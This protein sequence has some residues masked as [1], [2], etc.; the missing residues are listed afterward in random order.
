[1]FF[2]IGALPPQDRYKIMTATIVPRPIAWI[3][4]LSR[5]GVL[6]A[7]PFSFFN[8]MGNDPPTVAIGIM[9]RAGLL[10]DTAANI[11]ETGEF[12][13]NLVAETDAS[14]MN[15]TCIDAPPEVDELALAELE[16]APSRFVAPPRIETARVAFECQAL[17]SLVTGPLQTI[18]IGRVLCA[19]VED[20]FVLDAER[21][22]IDTPS[23]ELIARMHGG[24]AYLRT[25]DL[26]HLKR[27]IWAEWRERVLRDEAGAES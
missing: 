10:K 24:E 7:A 2:D 15:T 23:L 8:M 4:T 18:V 14:A 27:P 13:V 16:A 25:S 9:P 11:L 17:T 6:N 26:F 19:H 3:T 5:D 12:V 20:R 1:M 22:H 21:C